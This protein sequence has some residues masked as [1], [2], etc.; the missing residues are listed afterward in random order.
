MAHDG[1]E[2]RDHSYYGAE[3]CHEHR[4]ASYNYLTEE[5]AEPVIAAL[6]D[7][8]LY[9]LCITDVDIVKGFYDA[10]SDLRF[11]T[12]KPRKIVE[13]PKALD[14]FRRYLELKETWPY[15]RGRRRFGQYIFERG[16]YRVS[17][18]DWEKLGLD[19]PREERILRSMGCDFESAEEAVEALRKVR[20][21]I[22][23]AAESF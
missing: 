16:V 19:R 4:C 9:G 2:M 1:L 18:I 12:V 15:H 7:W 5:S 8:Y 17:D 20:A 6:D 13:N 10:V 3:M 22:S 14:A 23:E 21:I 11:E